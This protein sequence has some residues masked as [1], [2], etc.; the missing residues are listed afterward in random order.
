MVL[1]VEDATEVRCQ[2]C[3]LQV[4]NKYM[5]VSPHVHSKIEIPLATASWLSKGKVLA[6][7]KGS[8]RV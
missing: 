6:R 2:L 3:A 4:Y 5:Y 8:Y 1:I 7:S